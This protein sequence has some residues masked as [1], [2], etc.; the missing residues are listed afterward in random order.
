MES[1][2][3]ARCGWLGSVRQAVAWEEAGHDTASR[4]RLANWQRQWTID[5]GDVLLQPVTRRI[6]EDV[7]A[8]GPITCTFETGALHD[9]IPQAM[10]VAIRDIDSGVAAVLPTVWL[11]VRRADERVLGDPGTHGPPDGEGCVE[12]GYSLAPSTRGKGVDT[13][14]VAAFVQRLPAVPGIRRVRLPV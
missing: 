7:L 13:A 9:R 8:G 10:G 3:A 5:A 2:I 11:I 4:S 1:T 6:A 12:I 14:V